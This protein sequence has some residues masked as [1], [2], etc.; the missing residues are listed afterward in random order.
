M[1]GGVTF[2][3]FSVMYLIISSPIALIVGSV[4]FSRIAATSSYWRFSP[5]DI[6]IAMGGG[7]SVSTIFNL[8]TNSAPLDH[9]GLVSG[10]ISATG[11][12]GTSI[13]LSVATVTIGAGTTTKSYQNAYYSCLAYSCVY[14][15]IGTFF[16][17]SS[18]DKSVG[19]GMQKKNMNEVNEE[20]ETKEASLPITEDVST[21][22]NESASR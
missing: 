16:I 11:Q 21:S 20:E 18:K 17:R 8:A 4:L 1:F 19:V 14:L 10:M 7:L 3:K 6:F 9:Q 22:S 15:A 13:G 5:G 12:M 2:G